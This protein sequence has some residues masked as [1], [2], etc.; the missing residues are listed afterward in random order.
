[1]TEDDVEPEK[2]QPQEPLLHTMPDGRVIDLN[3]LPEGWV[4]IPGIYTGPDRRTKPT[5]MFSR[6]LFWGKRFANLNTTENAQDYFTD[7]I[8]KHAWKFFFATFILSTIDACFSI[9][10]IVFHSYEEV[11]PILNPFIGHSSWAF[12]LVKYLFTLLGLLFLIVHQHFHIFKYVVILVITL[13][14]VL[15]I[16]HLYILFTGFI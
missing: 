13:Y 6:F 11:N 4:H 10:Y 5:P 15:C 7:R 9:Y 14:T 2:Q 1:M 8:H 12:L 3:K 16:Y